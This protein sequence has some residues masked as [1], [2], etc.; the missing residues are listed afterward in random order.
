MLEKFNTLFAVVKLLI[1]RIVGIID[2]LNIMK[3]Y[4]DATAR[5][6]R[7]SENDSKYFLSH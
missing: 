3:K 1:I 5:R 7:L 4:L 2:K 6:S